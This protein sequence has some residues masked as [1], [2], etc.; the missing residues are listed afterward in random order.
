M[1]GQH[2]AVT[3]LAHRL[4]DPVHRHGA[5]LR[6]RRQAYHRLPALAAAHHE[7][8][9]G[10]GR[11]LPRHHLEG[12]P[13]EGQGRAGHTLGTRDRELQALAR[14]GPPLGQPALP[15]RAVCGGE[16][17]RLHVPGGSGVETP[18][19]RPFGRGRRLQHHPVRLREGRGPPELPVVGAQ[20]HGDAGVL[21]PHAR[22]GHRLPGEEGDLHHQPRSGRR[23]AHHPRVHL[24]LEPEPQG[25]LDPQQRR[26]RAGRQ[27]VARALGRTLAHQADHPLGLSVRPEAVHPPALGAHLH[28]ARAQGERQLEPG[29]GG[30]QRPLQHDPVPARADPGPEHACLVPGQRRRGLPV[31]QH[32]PRH[33]AGPPAGERHRHVGE[34]QDLEVQTQGVTRDLEPHARGLGAAGR[35]LGWREQADPQVLQELRRRELRPGLGRERQARGEQ[36]HEGADREDRRD[37]E[38][39]GACEGPGGYDGG[40][41]PRGGGTFGGGGGCAGNGGAARGRRRRRTS[42]SPRRG[43]R[44]AEPPRERDQQERHQQVPEEAPGGRHEPEPDLPSPFHRPAEAEPRPVPVPGGKPGAGLD[45]GLRVVALERPLQ[46]HGRRGGGDRARGRPQARRLRRLHGGDDGLLQGFRRL[47]HQRD[48]CLHLLPRRDRRLVDHLP[49]AL[50]H[51]EERD[52]D[53]RDDE[54]DG[55][56]REPCEGR[57]AQELDRGAQPPLG[58]HPQQRHRRQQIEPGGERHPLLVVTEPEGPERE[59]APAPAPELA[60]RRAHHEQQEEVEERPAVEPGLGRLV[61]T[62][63]GEEPPTGRQVQRRPHP[64]EALGPAERRQAGDVPLDPALGGEVEPPAPHLDPLAR[65]AG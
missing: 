63:R 12:R 61:H 40:R 62:P 27:R 56:H 33:P 2:H 1:H 35:A 23:E 60:D 10:V 26:E 11:A 15:R 65:G 25:P 28:P 34:R 53:L 41:A 59:Q 48:V 20:A 42:P 31:H 9:V 29:A 36:R 54:R 64:L 3:V 37:R 44:P 50:E 58:Q 18:G 24:P 39:P 22:A 13:V 14:P 7:P 38:G 46:G 57:P 30:G 51:R 43:I 16:P 19:L 49:G 8:Q 52:A 45:R 4:G 21:H 55:Q 5:E 32:L 17:R 47:G 6:V